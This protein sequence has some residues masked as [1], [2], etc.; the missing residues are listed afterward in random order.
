MG[1]LAQVTD[2]S[3]QVPV[4]DG[5]RPRPKPPTEAAR[6]ARAKFFLRHVQAHT[7]AFNTY[8]RT[9]KS[10]WGRVVVEASKKARQSVRQTAREEDKRE[11]ERLRAL[12]ANDMASY[13]SLLE[14]KKQERLQYL[15]EQTE[16][17]LRKLSSLIAKQQES[18]EAQDRQVG[19]TT[20]GGAVGEGE[21][22]HVR[23]TCR[24]RTASRWLRRQRRRRRTRSRSRP[25]SARRSA[26]PR[27]PRTPQR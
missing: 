22:C 16:M 9:A 21:T 8:H 10:E 20:T 19:A 6:A 24:L 1:P 23:P 27:P 12:K 2:P 13:K 11:R 26:L 4:V 7:I 14:G 17:Y 25:T 3:R 15:I 18:N 5:G